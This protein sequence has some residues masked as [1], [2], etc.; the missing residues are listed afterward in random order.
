MLATGAAAASRGS[1]C[2]SSPDWPCARWWRGLLAVMRPLARGSRSAR[3]SCCMRVLPGATPQAAVVACVRP[4]RVPLV[5][6]SQA[7]AGS[8]PRGGCGRD[9]RQWRPRRQ[10]TLAALL[11]WAAARCCWRRLLHASILSSWPVPPH[12]CISAAASRPQLKSRRSPAPVDA[13][14]PQ[15]QGPRRQGREEGRSA[16]WLLMRWS[17]KRRECGAGSK[18]ACR[19]AGRGRHTVQ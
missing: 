13:P 19:T 11:L 6:G 17:C 2:S 15:L 9:E 3:R 16:D 8:A 14:A 5:A 1:S 12:A 4:S 10:Q 7:A 18:G